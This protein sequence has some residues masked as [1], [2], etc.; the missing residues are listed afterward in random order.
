MTATL[1]SYGLVDSIEC[2]RTDKEEWVAVA[3]VAGS[4]EDMIPSQTYKATPRV[5]LSRDGSSGDA[6][7]GIS[8]GIMCGAN[9]RIDPARSSGV[10]VAV[11]GLRSKRGNLKIRSI[12]CVTMTPIRRKDVET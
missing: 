1:I 10:A 3:L 7:G 9:R 5:C 8:L 4:F 11:G 6:V 12:G 2:G